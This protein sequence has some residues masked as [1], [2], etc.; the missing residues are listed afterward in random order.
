MEEKR[1]IKEWIKEHK[2]G[3]IITGVTVASVIGVIIIANKIEL[4]SHSPLPA[5]TK[6]KDI[7]ALS[8]SECKVIDFSTS[9]KSI[10]VSEH[11]RNL[12]E[13]WNAS[14]VKIALA[15]EHGYELAPHQT[16]VNSYSKCA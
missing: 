3:L 15:T 6:L 8:N 5:N 2:T 12:P 1:T 13:R 7:P 16:W 10:D 4:P 9:K 11:L 14:P